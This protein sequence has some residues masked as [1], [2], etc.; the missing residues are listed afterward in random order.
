MR[1][2]I[3]AFA[4]LAAL[5]CSKQTPSEESAAQASPPAFPSLDS[6][7]YCAR[8]AA[9]AGS[10]AIE[11]DCKEQEA[12][13]RKA[14]MAMTAPATTLSYCAR[15]AEAAGGSYQILKLCVD[16]EISAPTRM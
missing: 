4:A 7:A 16:K 12:A 5:A 10:P 6:D 3:L 15:T 13:A 1:G 2:F 8:I 14:A 11:K 9:G